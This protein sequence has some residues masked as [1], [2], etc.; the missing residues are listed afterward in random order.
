VGGAGALEKLRYL[1]GVLDLNLLLT[2]IAELL[3]NEILFFG[4]YWKREL[5]TIPFPIGN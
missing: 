4:Y 2:S 1:V 3:L 5:L